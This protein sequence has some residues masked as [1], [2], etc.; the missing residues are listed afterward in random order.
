MADIIVETKDQKR[1]R[2]N[3]SGRKPEKNRTDDLSDG[4]KKFLQL[5]NVISRHQN[6][7]TAFGDFLDYCLKIMNIMYE[8]PSF[9]DIEKKYTHP[10]EADAF[11]EMFKLLGELSDDNGVGF[12]DFLGDFYQI[13]ISVGKLGQFFTPIP[14]CDFMAQINIGSRGDMEA[15]VQHGKRVLDPACGSGRFLLSAAKIIGRD[16]YFYASDIDINCAKMAVINLM[17]NS[18]EGE[19]AWMDALLMKPWK[20]WHIEL[21]NTSGGYI[22]YF[23]DGDLEDN[24]FIRKVQK[25]M[26]EKSAPSV[27]ETKTGEAQQLTFF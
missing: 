25:E 11:L 24:G 4:G 17:L 2:E 18:M 9:E 15:Q 21:V 26:A 12:Y 13:N 1:K 16:N 14:L 10:Q 20:I 23:V 7:V 3:D 19:V 22:P 5:F 6:G 8:T 27:P